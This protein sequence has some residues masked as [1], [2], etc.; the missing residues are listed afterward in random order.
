MRKF[1]LSGLMVF[2]VCAST[3]FGQ[4]PRNEANRL[5][6]G[7]VMP[8]EAVEEVITFQN[9]TAKNLEIENIQL[10]P[11][12]VAKD[13]TRVILPGAEGGF[14]LVLGKD[15]ELGLYEGMFRINFKEAA[16]P[17]LI[18]EVEGFVIPPI[19]FKPFPAFFVATHSGKQKVA[20]IEIINH[21][22]EPLVLTGTE[23]ASERFTAALETIE[24]GRHYRLSLTLDGTAEPGEKQEEIILMAD[25]PTEKPLRVQAN[26]RIRTRVYN[27]P[28]VVDMGALPLKV[29]TDDGSVRGLSQTLMVYRPDTD[30]FEVEASVN[31]DYIALKIE[32]GPNGDRYQLT[33]TLI[34]EKVT[35]R[36]IE[37]VV[38]IRTNDKEF[39][40]VEVPVTGYILEKKGS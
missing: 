14:R 9:T 32:R 38:R 7:R 13:L 40:I 11:P 5:S 30:D 36:E 27:F 23:S 6:F 10:T 2:A 3:S 35:P 21:R 8:D 19:E 15:R 24:T 39:S 26:T 16:H 20:S 17:P 33:L 29:A 31:L 22:D 34:P 18:F 37:G 25:P 1:L 28:D 12:L 4:Q